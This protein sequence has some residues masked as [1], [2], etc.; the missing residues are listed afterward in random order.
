M[1]RAGKVSRGV[2]AST[3]GTLVAT[4][5][6]DQIDIAWQLL[7]DAPISVALHARRIALVGYDVVD[8][9]YVNERELRPLGGSMAKHEFKLAGIED[10]HYHDFRHTAIINVRRAGSTRLQVC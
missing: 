6:L 3:H 2:S 9:F 1:R 8:S 4:D 10:V 5:F 7:R